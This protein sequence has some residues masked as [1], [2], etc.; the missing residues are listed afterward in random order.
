MTAQTEPPLRWLRS[1]YWRIALT[2]VIVMVAV[3]GAQ[4]LLFSYLVARWN[5]QD[6]SR[7]PMG[8]ARA[9][10]AELS[11]ALEDDPALDVD[12]HLRSRYGRVPYSLFVF[13]RNGHVAG[14]GVGTPAPEVLQFAQS[15]LARA[16][17]RMPGRGR[18]LGRGR[19]GRPF[20][21]APVEVN[22]EL[23][24][25][26]VVPPP[27]TGVLW[28]LQRWL[29]WPGTIVLVIGTIVAAIL[30]FA[31]ARR[32]L[33]ALEAAAERFGRG[34]PHARA[35]D[36]GGDEIARVAR[37]FNRMARELS[38]RDEALRASD[39]LRRQMLADVS[40]ELKTPLTSIRA[41][42]ETLRMPD[43]AA[44]AERRTRY[45]AT[46]EQETR[47]LERLVADLL[48][49]ARHESGMSTMEPRVFSVERLFAQV[50]ARHEHEAHARGVTIE[51]SVQDAADEL[52][53]DP[54]RIDQAIDNLV[55]N[56]LRHTPGSGRITLR[57]ARQEDEVLLSVIDTGEGIAPEHL[58]HVFE[59]FYKVD[60]SRPGGMAGSGLGLSIVK[61][62]VE[63]HGGTVRV[64]SVPG[65]TE[66]TI[67]LPVH[68]RS[69]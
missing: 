65:R 5:A 67:V 11:S 29:S 58:A 41:Y 16:D 60:P 63:R 42:I 25:L 14:N 59:R 33:Q 27:R 64:T 51:T 37:A 47:R 48:D 6:P 44:D 62:I 1:F 18:R 7:T 66:F 31:P 3:I 22:G 53:A 23:R 49:L 45:F 10:A 38:A 32:R 2:F 8:V 24:G 34:D 54:H 12:A 35:P 55:V 50:V 20:V 36:E 68:P 39:R 46:M 43:I 17:A 19:M 30:V 57:A 56:A 15:A 4:G 40:H 21:A 52:T 26:V 69:A 61:A 13:L 28:L 9:A